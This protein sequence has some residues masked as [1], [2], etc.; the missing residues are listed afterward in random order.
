[1]NTWLRIAFVTFLG[2]AASAGAA[3]FARV[4]LK[5]VWPN[6]ADFAPA[7]LRAS[8]KARQLGFVEGLS[9]FLYALKSGHWAQLPNDERL[10]RVK[11]LSS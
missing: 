9:H 8:I 10:R 1:M 2:S 6:G 11:R 3:D 5:L 4:T 7:F